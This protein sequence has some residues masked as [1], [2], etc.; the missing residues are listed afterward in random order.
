MKTSPVAFLSYAHRDDEH[1]GGAITQLRA[2]LS[3]ATAVA[4]GDDFEIFQDRKDIAWGNHWPSKL[5]HGLAGSRFLIAILSPS[6]FNSEY[7]RKELTDFLEVEKAA[8][9]N[10]LILPIYYVPTPL[11][12]NP[13]QQDSDPLA[14]AISQR[15]YRDWRE[16]RYFPFDHFKIRRALNSLAQELVQAMERSDEIAGTMP[17]DRAFEMPFDDQNVGPGLLEGGDTP[18]DLVD[19]FRQGGLMETPTLF[20]AKDASG[21]PEP[22]TVF[23]DIDKS[24]CPAMVVIPSG[25][26]IMGSP[27]EEEGHQDNE[28][29]EHRVRIAKPFAL[30]IYP[31]TFGEFDH[32]CVETGRRKP[33]DHGWGRVRRPVINVNAEEAEAYLTWLSETTGQHYGLPSEAM[34]EYACRAQTT[35]PFWTGANITTDQANYDGNHPYGDA[36]K[37]QYREQTTDVGSFPDNSFGLFDMHGN[38]WE[39]CADHWH[40]TYDGAPGDGSAWL[41][42]SDASRRVLR[43]GSWY[44]S[45]LSLRSACRYGSAPVERSDGIGFRCARVQESSK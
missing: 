13:T 27:R 10:D 20:L 1:H 28:E 3:G 15:Q 23:R 41:D 18:E 11:L 2:A 33:N 19:D 6:F 31:V 37:G 32:F 38:V 39:W 34:W 8:G 44:V 25:S 7:C 5:E 16:L 29:P 17:T 36:E 26:F 24:W 4:I 35:T 22:G 14:Q 43:G 40:D 21:L 9:R 30:G 45:A 12:E 42:V